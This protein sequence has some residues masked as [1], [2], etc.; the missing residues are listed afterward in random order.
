MKIEKIED[1]ALLFIL[2]RKARLTLREVADKARIEP[3]RIEQVSCGRAD[4]ANGFTV[5][6]RR[7]IAK[8]LRVPAD[9]LT[10]ETT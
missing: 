8:V 7:R 1:A 5:S 3:W 4:L 2:R 6:E 10:S 9:I